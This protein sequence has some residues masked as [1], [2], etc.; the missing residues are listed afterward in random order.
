MQQLFVTAASAAQAQLI[1]VLDGDTD[2]VSTTNGNVVLDI[3]PLV[4]KLGDRFQFV[5]NLAERDPAGLHPGDDPA[6][7]RP[8]H[9][10]GPHPGAQGDAPN[11]IWVLALAAWAAALWL[12]PGRRRKE[13][14]AIGVG[15]IV[16][17]MLVLVIR[18]SRGELLRRQPRHHRVRPAGRE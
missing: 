13:V 7:G 5:T 11:W 6:V 10:A 15:L 12:V 3:R 2:V 14:R 18:S 4:L 1:A 16:A 8:E 9:G 17:G